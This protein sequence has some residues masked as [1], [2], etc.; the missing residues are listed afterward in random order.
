MHD[1]LFESAIVKITNGN[2]SQLTATE[3]KS[4]STVSISTQYVDSN[5][6]VEDSAS[7][8]YFEILK[9]K[10]RKLSIGSQFVDYIF[11]AAISSSVE[12]A[13]SAP[14]WVLITIR[15]SIFPIIFEVILFLKLNRHFGI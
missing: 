6:E 3:R 15:K 2:E 10:R 4:V 13:F 11:D 7:V 9:A 1:G 8:S 5:G 14:L 12:R